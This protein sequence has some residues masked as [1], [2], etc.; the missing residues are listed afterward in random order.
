MQETGVNAR[1]IVTSIRG[2]LQTYTTPQPA[3][4]SAANVR[5]TASDLGANFAAV[6]KCVGLT[7]RQN[8]IMKLVLAGSPSKNIASDLHINER[9]VEN[10]RAKIRR[11]MGVKSLAAMIRT[12]LCDGCDK[13]HNRDDLLEERRVMLEE[14]QHRVGNALR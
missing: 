6:K 12:G 8:Q 2:P 10:H 1:S 5:R 11:K 9:T 13:L 3:C 7:P 14:M 4:V